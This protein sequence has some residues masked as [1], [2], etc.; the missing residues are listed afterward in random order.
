MSKIEVLRVPDGLEVRDKTT[1]QY[2]WRTKI[3]TGW[4][5]ALLAALLEDVD[6]NTAYDLGVVAGRYLERERLKD[7]KELVAAIL[8]DAGAVKIGV[9][10][11]RLFQLNG[12]VYKPDPGEFWL[13]RIR[14]EGEE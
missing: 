2:P 8:K 9:A 11:G 13:L 3:P 10:S 6:D 1:R 12:D 5:P 14:E 4:H 7:D